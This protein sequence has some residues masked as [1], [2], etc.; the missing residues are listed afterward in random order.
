VCRDAVVDLSNDGDDDNN[1]AAGAQGGQQRQQDEQDQQ[2]PPED[3]RED[4]EEEEGRRRQR[5]KK[6]ASS[7]VPSSLF[8][9]G[10]HYRT[11]PIDVAEILVSP[12]SVTY[13]V[14]HVVGEN[15]KDDDP[16]D[17]MMERPGNK[18]QQQQQGSPSGGAGGVNEK[19]EKMAVFWVVA[20]KTR[21]C[22][23]FNKHLETMINDLDKEE[24]SRVQKLAA[25]EF[26]EVMNMMREVFLFQYKNS[27]N[28]ITHLKKEGG[29]NRVD[30]F[31][32]LSEMCAPD[33]LDSICSVYEAYRSIVQQIDD[34]GNYIC[35]IFEANA[36]LQAP[37][38][39]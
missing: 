31:Q 17:R 2:Q 32:R 19:K 37:C 4:Q 27:P 3:R 13:S 38:T 11:R 14:P 16:L 39:C 20:L 33:S 36:P 23:N 25:K 28:V 6:K 21:K 5:R 24:K 12:V 34:L 1:E 18:Q 30:P 10:K 8:R 9:G 7:S 15:S 35:F 22:Y 26:V 29:G